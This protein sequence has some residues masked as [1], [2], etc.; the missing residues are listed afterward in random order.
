MLINQTAR[1]RFRE[2]QKTKSLMM[3]LRESVASVVQSI[4]K[5][6]PKPLEAVREKTN[7]NLQINTLSL[8]KL[9]NIV[10]S[11][12]ALKDSLPS[13]EDLQAVL[14]TIQG[15]ELPR[16]P[17]QVTINPEQIT[18]LNQSINGIKIPAIPKEVTVS[19][20]SEVIKTLQE[21]KSALNRP[22]TIQAPKPEQPIITFN[23]VLNFN[24]L[25]KELQRI[26]LNQNVKTKDNTPALIE[27]IR[28]LADKLDSLKAPEIKF[29]KTVTVDNFPVQM[30]PQPVTHISINALQG[31]IKTTSTTVGTTLTTLPGYGQLLNRRSVVIYNN[32]ANTVFIGGSDVTTSNGLPVPS[33][34]ASPVFDAG[35]NVILYGIASTLGNDIRVTEISDEASGR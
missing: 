8:A 18:S 28:I 31:F 15:I 26:S 14:T 25:L 27:E 30:T 19:N 16:P 4:P 11:L 2:E 32:S 24:P 22:I 17:E 10:E 5:P 29:P 7:A 3:G 20:L 33:G 21:V 6:D 13:K 23:P 12:V 9:Q 35:Y 34:T 1:N